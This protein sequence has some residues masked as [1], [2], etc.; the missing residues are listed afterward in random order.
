MAGH[1]PPIVKPVNAK[2]KHAGEI[3]AQLKYDTTRAGL[4]EAAG[5]PNQQRIII[6]SSNSVCGG[7]NH[8]DGPL[9]LDA[10]GELRTSSYMHMLKR[11]IA[12]VVVPGQ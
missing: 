9:R 1:D 11:S 2:G 4:K 5:E 8:T 10:R 12:C 3:S 7:G 6:S